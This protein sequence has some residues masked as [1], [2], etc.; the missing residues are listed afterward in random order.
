M[1][2]HSG[3]TLEIFIEQQLPA[4]ELWVVGVTPIARSLADLGMRAGWQVTAIDPSAS[5]ELF[6][7]GVRAQL[8]AT[9]P[10][11]TRIVRSTSAS[12]C[13]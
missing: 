8:P 1:T 13:P 3:G 6:P 9:S 4:P 7:D 12:V 11:S 2:C 5:G 10:G